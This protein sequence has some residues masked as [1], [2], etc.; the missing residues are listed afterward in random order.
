MLKGDIITALELKKGFST[1]IQW[2]G[3]CISTAG[4]MGWIPGLGT[5]ILHAP[6]HGQ[7]NVKN[8]KIL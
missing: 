2:L 1:V 5:N 3:L 8:F 6:W 7:K 4:G